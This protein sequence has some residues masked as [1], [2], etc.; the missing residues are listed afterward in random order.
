MER[1][2]AALVAVDPDPPAVIGHYRLNDGEAETGA[3]LFRRVVR[4]EQTLAFFVGQ[5][6]AAV[7]YIDSDRSRRAAREDR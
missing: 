3:V 1:R 6:G 7:G 4:R 2:A 5:P